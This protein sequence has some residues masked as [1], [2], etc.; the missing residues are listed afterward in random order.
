MATRHLLAPVTFV[1]DVE[2]FQYIFLPIQSHPD[3]LRVFCS[4]NNCHQLPAILALAFDVPG[5]CQSV[6]SLTHGV[7]E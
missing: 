3:L 5:Y 2:L 4:A 1:D 6:A 7:D